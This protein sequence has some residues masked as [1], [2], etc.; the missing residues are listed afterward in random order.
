MELGFARAYVC[1]E[2]KTTKGTVRD[3]TMETGF[4]DTT[5]AEYYDATYCGRGHETIVG[6]ALWGYYDFWAEGQVVKSTRSVSL[7]TR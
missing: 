1:L 5:G 3:N 7:R 6:V 2:K 4:E